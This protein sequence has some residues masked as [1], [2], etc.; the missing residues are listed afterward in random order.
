MLLSKAIGGL[1]TEP[2]YFWNIFEVRIPI[3]YVCLPFSCEL[4]RG[5]DPHVD[6]P[7]HCHV[8]TLFALATVG[9]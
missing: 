9:D 3:Y 2:K 7:N 8:S 5:I 6:D 1:P 4:Q